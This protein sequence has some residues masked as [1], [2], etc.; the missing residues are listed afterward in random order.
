MRHT[1]IHPLAEPT[2]VANPSPQA[3]LDAGLPLPTRPS[4]K[5]HPIW[6]RM[7]H[8]IN[9][10]AVVVMVGS[11][12]RIFNA[13]PLFDLRFPNQVTLGSWLGGGLQWHFAGMWLLAVNGL[14]YLG[15]NLSTG[16]LARKFFPLTAAAVW[17]DLRAA[18]RGR[19]SHADPSQY[20]GLQRLAYLFVVVDLM[21]LVASGLVL[22][23]SVQFPLLRDLLGGYDTARWLHF[24]AM[25]GL[26]LFVAGHLLMVALV[27]RTLVAMV[28]GH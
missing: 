6:L 14:L 4:T 18:A 17:H 8:W 7:T 20:N 28:R 3:V 25:G 26:V 21:L 23:K 22:W 13:S 15:M 27:P 1:S 19:L 16:R 24:G 11:G 12:W 5:I 10:L 2:A 9:V